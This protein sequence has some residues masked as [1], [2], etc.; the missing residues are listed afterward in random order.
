[1]SCCIVLYRIIL[2]ADFLILCFGQGPRVWPCRWEPRRRHQGVDDA[3]L[4]TALPKRAPEP[5]NASCQKQATYILYM[6]LHIYIY[7]FVYV[8]MHIDS[9]YIYIHAFVHVCIHVYIGV[10]IY[11][12]VCTHICTHAFLQRSGRKRH[13]HQIGMV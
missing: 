3:Q 9:I 13:R 4:H 1:M 11:I 7:T 6:Y 8:F 12:Y 2:D 10:H 5:P